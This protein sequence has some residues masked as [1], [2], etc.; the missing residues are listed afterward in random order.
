MPESVIVENC[1]PTLAGIKTGNLFSIPRNE[2]GD[3]YEELRQLNSVLTDKG[4]RAVPA[5]ITAKSVLIYLYRPDK[6]EQDLED[7]DAREILYQKG[8]RCN[9][10]E[11]YVASLIQHLSEDS[12]FP[13]EIGLFLGYPPIDVKGFM[14]NTRQGVKCVGYWKVYGDQK[15]AE[16]TFNRY[17]KCTDI[18]KQ[19]FAKGKPMSQMIVSSTSCRA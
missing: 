5:K 15:K 16:Q 10:T 18:Y 17:K 1:S 9:C 3:V 13:H 4:L 6:L 11:E 7:T 12:N 19:V 2:I 8:Y 14:N